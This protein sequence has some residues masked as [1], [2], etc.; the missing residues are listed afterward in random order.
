MVGMPYVDPELTGDKLMKYAIEPMCRDYG[1]GL[2]LG[3]VALAAQHRVGYELDAW[4]KL[5]HV[6]AADAEL[7]LRMIKM[8]RSHDQASA[9][10]K[11]STT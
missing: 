7:A 11:G 6:T 4:G 10:A 9:E 2:I 1:D 5:P 3:A 8:I